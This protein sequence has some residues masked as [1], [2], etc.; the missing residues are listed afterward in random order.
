MTI[1]YSSLEV[2]RAIERLFA[3]HDTER[4]AITAFVGDG[5]ESY[6]PHPKG[7]RLICWP[8]VGS[9]NPKVLQSLYRRGALIEFVNLLHMKVYWAHEMGAVVASA[10]LTSNALGAGDL[11]ECGVF[12]KP[13]E[14]DIHRLI[15]SL[16]RIP[17][18]QGI[19]A[20]VKGHKEFRNQLN[21]HASSYR[22]FSEWFALPR[23]ERW[24]IAVWT[25][26]AKHFSMEALREARSL[27]GKSPESSV[28]CYQE[29]E[30]RADEWVLC[31]RVNRRGSPLSFEW[32]MPEKVVESSR[33]VRENTN[34][35]Y[36]VIQLS[37]LR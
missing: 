3:N 24:R 32:F 28:W 29:D 7:L 4:V 17:Y 12:L 16:K 20:L 1:L 35:K 15:G 25:S 31:V 27:R 21:M 13:G 37:P 8:K 11:K 36:E 6:L 30:L 34:L 9:T 5:A 18:S 10:N 19:G 33:A 22:D 23:R 14:L 26:F 2:R